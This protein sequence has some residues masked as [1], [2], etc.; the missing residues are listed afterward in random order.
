MSP[1]IR[2]SDS[3]Y[4]RLEKY[5]VG[6]DAPSNVIERLIEYYESNKNHINRSNP[7]SETANIILSRPSSSIKVSRNPE[8]E[9]QLKKSFGKKL[10]WGNFRIISKT[11]LDFYESSK[12]VLCK[13]SSYSSELERWFWGVGQKY[14]SI[15][16]DN[17]YLALLME[18]IDKKS[19]SYIL[20]KPQEALDLFSHCSE[21]NGEKK[22]NLRLY[23]SDGKLHLQEWQEY[24][25][26][27]NA[28]TL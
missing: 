13:Y 10:N 24:N 5:A 16:S 17:W 25:V 19:Y 28:Q 4:K 6:F 7:E 11:V 2:I 9:L 20:L 27:D 18:N 14:H 23:K 15:W 12:K 8:K 1:V 3:I 26:E 21:S 22:I